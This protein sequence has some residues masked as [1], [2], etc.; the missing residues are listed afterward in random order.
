[1]L[2]YLLNGRDR[3]PVKNTIPAHMVTEAMR[4]AMK[5]GART[6]LTDDRGRKLMTILPNPL[7]EER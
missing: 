5:T 2:P 3:F 6:S 7:F 4:L 1:M